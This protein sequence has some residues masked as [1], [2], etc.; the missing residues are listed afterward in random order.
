MNRDAA[1]QTRLDQLGATGDDADQVLVPQA[2][3]QLHEH[4]RAAARALDE[5]EQRVVGLG[6][7]DVLGHL[8]HGGIV[9]RAE[10]DPLGAAV[11][12][13]LDRA[14][15]LRRALV[16]AEGEDPGHRQVGEAHGQ[17]EQRRRGPAVSPLQ[18]VERDHQRPV[19]GGA[20][21]QH[22]QVLQQPVALLGQRA[23][24]RQPGSLE[25]RVRAVEQRGHQRRELDHASPGL[26]RASA[27]PEREPPRD[28]VRLG[29]QSGLAHPRLSLDEHHRPDT[30]AHAIKL[31]ADR[32]EF[33][34]PTANNGSAGGRQA[35]IS[36]S[37][38]LAEARFA[39]ARL[40]AGAAPSAD[41][42]LAT[43][44]V[45]TERPEGMRCIGG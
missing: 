43:T 33:S 7:D 4:E 38:A 16:G 5:V 21:E 23:K 26:G 12:Q 32:R 40:R 34:V 45:G 30:R 29:Q 28:P 35:Q 1:G 37:T 31:N 10:D 8:G 27:H 15:D 11:V 18:V 44:S 13:M 36:E 41:A 6:V 24:L 3:Q 39:V 22:L 2:G 14:E 9:E 42:P 19:E 17:R 20:L 25:Q